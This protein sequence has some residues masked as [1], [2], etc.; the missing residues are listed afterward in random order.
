MVGLILWFLEPACGFKTVALRGKGNFFF[1]STSSG[2]TCG[3][4]VFRAPKGLRYREMK[5]K[6]SRGEVVFILNM[7]VLPRN[8]HGFSSAREDGRAC[9]FLR[10]AA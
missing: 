3:L 4:E 6:T 2:A 8:V 1:G 7:G 10:F 9:R 5:Q